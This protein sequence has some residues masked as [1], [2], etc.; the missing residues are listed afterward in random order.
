SDYGNIDLAAP[1]G[2]Q[3]SSYYDGVV[4]TASTT[5]QYEYVQGTSYSGPYVAAAVALVLSAGAPRHNAN[6]IEPEAVVALKETADP[7]G[8]TVPDPELGY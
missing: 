6:T 7:R 4:T 5:Q 1:G 2:D 3:E 8:R